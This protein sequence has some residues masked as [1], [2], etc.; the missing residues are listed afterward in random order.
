MSEMTMMTNTTPKKLASEFLF[1]WPI[2]AMIWDRKKSII[3]S[4][5][6]LAIISAGKLQWYMVVQQKIYIFVGKR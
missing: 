5:I 1:W 6:A 4:L 3:D 2:H